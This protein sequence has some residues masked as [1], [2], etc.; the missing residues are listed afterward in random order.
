M[1]ARYLGL[2]PQQI[3]MVAAHPTDLQ[4]AQAVGLRTAFIPRPLEHGPSHVYELPS[5]AAFD[6]VEANGDVLVYT[7]PILAGDP[8]TAVDRL[9]SALEKG[10]KKLPTV[11][12]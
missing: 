10:F 3:M 1:A 9:R 8:T 5:A 7:D 6:V 4:A 2:R 11:S 12:P